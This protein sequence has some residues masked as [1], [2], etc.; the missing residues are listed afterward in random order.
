MWILVFKGLKDERVG[1]IVD[2][3]ADVTWNLLELSLFINYDL[4]HDFSLMFALSLSSI[5]YTSFSLV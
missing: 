1:C 4:V 2:W 5:Y 3:F